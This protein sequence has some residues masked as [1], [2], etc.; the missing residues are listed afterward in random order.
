MTNFEQYKDFFLKTL[1]EKG[2][3]CI[4]L[5]KGKPRP[6]D[7][8]SC[9]LCDIYGEK[10]GCQNNIKKWLQ[11]E[12]KE[13]VIDWAKVPVDTKILVRNDENEQWFP[14]YFAE[15]DIETNHVFAWYAGRTS[16]TETETMEW[17][18]AKLAE[19]TKK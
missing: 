1:E 5:V 8:I 19:E 16:W 11:E 18:F 12:Y 10:D 2:T 17:R 15:Y 7:E 14:R 3:M 6:C 9:S 4:G 13:P